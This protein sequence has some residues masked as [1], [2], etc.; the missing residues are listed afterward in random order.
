MP[1]FAG[2]SQA[3]LD[4]IDRHMVPLAWATGE[5]LYH[6]GAV[7]A[8]MYVLA[9]G[10]AKATR[11][12]SGGHEVVVDMFAPGDLFGGLETLGQPEHGE[13]VTALTTTCAL[14][15]D[16][17]NFRDVLT[18]YPQV[19]L[20]VLD[21]LAGRL[22]R[23]HSTITEQST[24]TAMQRVA[25][26]LLRLADKFG[27][28]RRD[29]GTLIQIPLTRT[30]LAGMS[31]TTTET[32]SRIMS[33]LRADGIIESGRRWTAIVDHKSLASIVADV[34]TRP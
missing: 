4:G 5:T 31:G 22:S 12:T 27:Q 23:A 3:E 19:A 32:V 24:A 7:A 21:D 28:P 34:A 9:S 16:A 1:L 25:A 30:D 29:G 14:R 15:I 13:T 33:T 2:S 6:A 26:A 10:R 11:T 8:H 20:H 17:D 18:E